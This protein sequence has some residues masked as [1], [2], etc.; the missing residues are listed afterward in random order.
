MTNMAVL[1]CVV[2]ACGLVCRYISEEHTFAIFKA[3]L[4]PDFTALHP[5][6]QS[7]LGLKMAAFP[8]KLKLCFMLL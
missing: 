2:T 4:L 8:T 7:F 3:K 1:L 5:R 6:R